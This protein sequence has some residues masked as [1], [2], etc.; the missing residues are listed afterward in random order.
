[1]LKILILTQEDTQ[2]VKPEAR[3]ET[4]EVTADAAGLVSH[5]GVALRVELTDR[6]GLTVALSEAFA[7]AG[8][9]LGARSGA[10]V[11]RCGGDAGGWR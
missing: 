8:A 10:G 11:A 5:A 4:V 9:A 1:L 2:L 6:V 7:D 3:L